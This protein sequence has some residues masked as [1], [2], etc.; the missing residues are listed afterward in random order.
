MDMVEFQYGGVSVAERFEV[1]LGDGVV[2]SV[3]VFVGSACACV[4]S[5]ESCL[6]SLGGV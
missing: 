3:R 2:V 1:W 4:K 5:R 6:V